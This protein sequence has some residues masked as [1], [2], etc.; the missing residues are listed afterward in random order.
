MNFHVVS[1]CKSLASRLG[2]MS[3]SGGVKFPT[4][5]CVLYSKSGELSIT[6][7]YKYEL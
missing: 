6:L 5:G 3:N 2:I 1:S 4:P 7:A